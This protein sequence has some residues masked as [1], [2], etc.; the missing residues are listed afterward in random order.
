MK[1]ER[2]DD[3]YELDIESRKR[4]FAERDHYYETL[5]QPIFQTVNPVK[6]DWVVENLLPAGYLT[7]LA[8][9]PK[10]GKTCLA[11]AVALAV[12]NGLP[13]AGRATTQ[14]AVL[15][16]AGEESY[17]ERSAILQ[18]CPIAEETTPLFTC[19]ERLNIDCEDDL[20]T[21]DHWR[22]HTEAKLIVVDPLLGCISGRSLAD[23]WSARKT[24]RTL[25][26]Y[27]TRNKVACLVLHHQ[28]RAYQRAMANRVA[29]NDQL[30]ATASLYWILRS[31]SMGVPPMCT[32]GVPP[33]KGEA[34]NPMER[35]RP[36]RE[37]EPTEHGER[38]TENGQ[39][40]VTLTAEGRGRWVERIT[41]FVS[42]SPLHYESLDVVHL[43]RA[44]EVHLTKSETQVLQ[45]LDNCPK[46]VGE[47]LD[48]TPIPE[49]LS[50]IAS[51]TLGARAKS[52][53]RPMASAPEFTKK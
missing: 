35:G 42:R 21:L 7:I 4:Y 27:C 12:A 15:W 25:K 30:A 52:G 39:R 38:K 6:P 41:R 43:D 48:T 37:S 45:A 31:S 32:E 50:G 26:E 17:Q 53:S 5:F 13:F 22:R 46:T 19:Y 23:S 14:S 20:M 2:P 34:C 49:K 33:S 44:P 47:I 18:S 28:K 24:L 11:T 36:V 8:G 10:S 40:L 51:Q 3:L 16:L 29:D 9:A 1:P